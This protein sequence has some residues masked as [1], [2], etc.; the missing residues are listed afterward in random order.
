ML[1]GLV[2]VPPQTFGLLR[3]AAVGQDDAAGVV[4]E[5]FD[6]RLETLLAGLCTYAGTVSQSCRQ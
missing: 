5:G 4:V 1:V 2:E 3:R 6:Q